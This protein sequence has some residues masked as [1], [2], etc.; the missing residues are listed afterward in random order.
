MPLRSHFNIDARGLNSFRRTRDKTNLV[1]HIRLLIQ[2]LFLITIFYLSTLAVWKGLLL[3]L[4]IGAP[5]V[6]GRFFCGWICPF[7]LY[8]DLITYLRKLLKLRYWIFPKKVNISLHYLRYI[9]AVIIL[10]SVLVPFFVGTASILNIAEFD[11]LRGP[12]RPL[13]MS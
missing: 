10:S 11:W 6:L 2:L 9:I 4:I 3:V 13:T 7:G 1:S 5:L 12:F 8:M